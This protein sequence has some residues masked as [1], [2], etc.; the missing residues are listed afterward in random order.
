MSAIAYHSKYVKGAIAADVCAFLLIFLFAYTGLSKLTFHDSFHLQLSKMQLIGNVAGFLSYAL[1]L[2]EIALAL[3]LL[4]PFTR[5]YGFYLSALLITL[6][7]LYLLW[8]VN[9][10]VKLPCSCG[11]VISKLSWQQHIV[12]NLFFILISLVGIRFQKRIIEPM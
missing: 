8:M 3:I 1:P 11:G 12:F 6:F 4:F 2:F 10:Q 7:T 5:M 9:N